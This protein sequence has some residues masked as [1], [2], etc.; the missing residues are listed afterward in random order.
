MPAPE[1]EGAAEARALA[2]AAVSG[3][4]VEVAGS[5]APDARTLAN[6]DGSLVLESYAVPRWTDRLGGWHQIDT[7]LRLDEGRVAPVA[8]LA[9]VRFSPGGVE[10]LAAWSVGGGQLGLSWSQPLPVPRLEG[11]TA[12]YADVLPEV[13]LRARALAD[14]LTWSVVVRSRQAAAHPALSSLRFG[15]SAS[16]LTVRG[17]AESGF[18][19]V[20]G[21]GVV[22]VSAGGALMW[23]SSGVEPAPAGRKAPRAA[24]GEGLREVPDHSRKAELPTIVDGDDLVIVPD[25]GLLLGSETV[26]PVVIDPWTTI[27]RMRWG[28]AGSTNATRDDGVARVGRD[29]DGSGN[30]RSFFAFNLSSLAGKTIRSVKFL[31][32]MTHSWS[33]GSTPVSLYR[34]EDLGSSGKQAWDGPNL[35][36]WLEERSGHAHKPSGGVGC[37]DDPQP[38]MPMEF[39]P[40][41]LKTDV[42]N[43]AGQPN[44]TL[45]LSARRSDGSGE[46]TQEYWKKFSPSATKLS[47]EYN[48]PPNTPTAA[49]LAMHADYTAPAQAC[50]SGTGRPAVRATRPWLKAV[51]TDPDGSN[52]GKLSGSFALQKWS[53]TSWGG[54]AG[55]PKTKSGVAPG[56]KAELQLGASDAVG[57]DLL[58]WQVRTSD[59]LGGTSAGWSPWC[60]FEVDGTPPELSPTVAA[61]DGV[62]LESPPDDQAR[63]GLGV[64]GRFTFGANGQADVYDYVYQLDDGVQRV[65]AAPILGGSVT[66]WVTPTHPLENV[67]TVRSRD[68]AGNAS[69]PYDYVFL[70]AEAPGPSTVWAMDEASGTTLTN[71]VAGGPTATISGAARGTGRLL[72][73]SV[74]TG[75]DRGL[76]FDGVNDAATTATAVVDTT[77]SFSVAAWL[78]VTPGA[79]GYRTAISQVGSSWSGF[80]LQRTAA[81]HWAFM[82]P[83]ADGSPTNVFAEAGDPAREGVWTHLA[84]V[85]DAH[86][87]QLRLYVNGQLAATNTRIGEWSATG[88]LVLGRAFSSGATTDWWNGDLGEVRIWHRVIDPEL[89]LAPLVEPVSSG[90]WEMEDFDEDTPRQESDLSEYQRSVTLSTG[91]S[92]LWCDGYNFSGGLCFDGS[93]G[94]AD[95]AT[96]VL[97]TE[98]SYTISA[99]VQMPATTDP[100]VRTAVSQ[101]GTNSH[102][103]RIG[104]NGAAD[105]FIFRTVPSDTIGAAGSTLSYVVTPAPPVGTWMHVAGVWDATAREM[106]L[107]VNGVRVSQ[108][109]AVGTPFAASGPLNIGKDKLNGVWGDYW[110]DGVDRVRVWTGALSDAQI[111]A[112]FTEP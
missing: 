91:T 6:P 111:T 64:S 81:G 109:T 61:A 56:A 12:V 77:K 31:T 108:T 11:D 50:V 8:T 87:A 27:N 82:M 35:Q 69:A 98:Q 46:S 106:R 15:L 80:Y 88:Q 89:D 34:S 26:F 100:A 63:G 76:S 103:T 49:Q 51:L 72:G 65:V 1:V 41:A 86:G 4:P 102:A 97:R 104:F 32:T 92:V 43:N 74:S 19:V 28:Y 45:A 52:G 20:D 79:T 96:P 37:S 22:V 105:Q 17:R 84:G 33:C 101:S 5:R 48:T 9:D 85:Y 2:A 44:Y 18:E 93:S 75:T 16:G 54:V 110:K 29:T 83:S 78:R 30:Y 13:D 107:Y 3:R 58:R 60:E 10:P 7:S 62:Y 99:W 68:Q 90:V 53:G 57:G 95:T 94:S 36:L 23:D 55:W 42:G 47:V 73:T 21:A 25:P 40:T 70:V 39:A 38:D 71:G 66:V 59:T 14:G 112:L 67:L 24:D